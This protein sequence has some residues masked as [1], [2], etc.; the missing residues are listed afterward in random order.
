MS[1][2]PSVQRVRDA[3]A[4]RGFTGEI[5]ELAQ[6]TRSAAE[7]AAALGC[8]V[9]QIAKSLVFRGAESDRVVLV[10]ACGA[11]RVDEMKVAAFVGEPI[12]KA[13]A[14]FVRARTGF[15]IGGVPPVGHAAA[16]HTLIDEDLLKWAEIWAAAGSPNAIF[17]LTPAELVAMTGGRVGP[18]GAS[19]VPRDATSAGDPGALVEAPHV[20]GRGRPAIE[21]R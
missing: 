7:A 16:P 3:L 14:A 11:N 13:D 17:R 19:P 12:A 4:A 5:R 15:A 9:D 20:S 21:S 1:L 8:Q 2:S 18:I 6:S 10:I